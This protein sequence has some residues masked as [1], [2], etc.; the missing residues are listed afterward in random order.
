MALTLAKWTLDDYHRMITAG[1]FTARHVE[2]L[3][4]EI[5][6]RP[7]EGPDNAGGSTSTR[8]YLSDL[9]GKRVLVR[10]EKPITLPLFGSEPEPDIAVVARQ[11]NFYRDR[12][13]YPEDIFLLIEFSGSS[14]QKDLEEKRDIYAAVGILEYWVVNL[15]D[16]K[17]ITFRNSVD[18]QY[19]VQ[20]E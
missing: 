16:R 20:Q 2:L 15:R 7:P 8:E 13:L 11:D 4:G 14:L 6:E 17:V 12:H 5:V 10:D 9:L 18:G 1:M 3:N 19:Q